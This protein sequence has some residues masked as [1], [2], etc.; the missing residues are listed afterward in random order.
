[1]VAEVI[2]LAE[3][4]V[5]GLTATGPIP[6]LIDRWLRHRPCLVFDEA[7][8]FEQTAS[9]T[10]LLIQRYRARLSN[11][12]PGCGAGMQPLAGRNNSG[13]LAALR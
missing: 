1:V 11:Y 4:C 8:A 5:A 3:N 9:V 7:Q 2:D 12:L 13:P 6:S 10:R